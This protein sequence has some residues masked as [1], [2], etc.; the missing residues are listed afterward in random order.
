MTPPTAYL[1]SLTDISVWLVI[2]SH[3]NDD[4]VM[5]I[6]THVHESASKTFDRILIVDS[7]GIGTLPTLIRDRGWQDVDYRCYSQNLGSGGN[8]CERLRLAAEGGADY[9]YAINHDGNFDRETYAKLINAAASI[10]NVGAVYPLSLFTSAGRYNLTGTRELP[11]PAKLVSK[12]PEASLIDVFWSS[13]N[14][15]LYSLTPAKRGILPW[16]I[17]WMAWED[18]EYGWRL[19][20]NR[21]RQV[22]V[23]D[24][25]YQDN[26]EYAQSWLGNTADKPAWRTYYNVRNLILAVR[27]SRNTPLFYAAVC[28]RLLREFALIVLAKNAKIERLG[29]LFRGTLDAW[30]TKIDRS[31]NFPRG[32]GKFQE[33]TPTSR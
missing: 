15:A 12:P 26:Y 6:L 18:L 13:S 22:I 30:R 4:E 20:S 10:S 1:A 25:V 31:D 23:C 28:Y 3:R 17:M 21:Y 7:E 19:A 11:L 29:C 27:R 9:A 8:L 32:P 33:A 14:G 5:Q 16:P 2:S 24:A